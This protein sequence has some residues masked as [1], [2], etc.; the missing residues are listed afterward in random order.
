MQALCD[1]DDA[2]GGWTIIQRRFDGSLDFDRS[3]REYKRGFG[4][5]Q[6][7]SVGE[8]WLGNEQIHL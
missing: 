7:D 6:C 3:W 8:L 2:G 1:M 5:W 4:Q